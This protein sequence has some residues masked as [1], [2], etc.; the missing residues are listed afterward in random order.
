MFDGAITITFY[1]KPTNKNIKTCFAYL[2]LLKIMGVYGNVEHPVFKNNL[3]F[4]Y[5]WL[6]IIIFI[7]FKSFWCADFKNDFFIKKNIIFLY[8][9]M[10]NFLKNIRNHTPKNTIYLTINATAT[11][12]PN[13]KIAKDN[14][15]GWEL[16][17]TNTNTTIRRQSKCKHV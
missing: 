6:K 15:Y 11:S 14:I 4:F 3:I 16:Q 12:A 13:I 8:F 9:D 7:C 10:K 17:F 5:F 1:M 2:C